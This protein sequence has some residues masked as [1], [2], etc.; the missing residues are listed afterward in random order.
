MSDFPLL[1][2]GEGHVVPRQ[3]GKSWPQTHP[4]LPTP[5]RQ[6][7]RFGPHFQRLEDAL[8]EGSDPLVLRDDPTGL[9]PERVLVF[10]VVGSVRDFNRA[11]E[12]I[13]G[14]EY[15]TESDTQFP[16]DN[17]FWVVDRRQG[18]EGQPRR[19]MPVGGCVYMA[20]PNLQALKELLSLWRIFR[21]DGEFGYGHAKWRNLFTQL[22]D[23]RIWGPQDRITP[24]VKD[25]FQYLLDNDTEASLMIAVEI[26]LWPR[27]SETARHQAF[28]AVSRIIGMADG[29]ILDHAEILQIGY[30]AV[31]AEVPRRVIERLAEEDDV[32]LAISD[33]IMYVRPQSAA[34]LLPSSDPSTSVPATVRREDLPSGRS[35]VAALLD[36]MPVQR[37]QGLDGQIIVDD[38]DGVE[39]ESPVAKRR[40]GTEMAS[41]IL[42]GDLAGSVPEPALSRPLHVHPVLWAPP[43]DA[44]EQER[45][46]PRRLLI[47]TFY[48]AVLRMKKGEGDGPPS[49]PDV[50]LINV[51]LGDRRRPYAN[52]ASPWARLL[53]YLACRFHL[54]FLVSAGNISEPLPIPGFQGLSAFE[55]A[56][57]EKRQLAILS[58]LGEQRARRTL[59]SPA[60]AI[61]VVTVGA[62]HDQAAESPDYTGALVDPIESRTLPNVSSALGLG[63]LRAIKPDI[64][65]PGGRE[66]VTP[67]LRTDGLAVRPARPGRAFGIQ[68]AA[69]DPTGRLDHYRPT[70]GTSAATALATHLAH[71][72]FDALTDP[73]NGN[74]LA[75]ANPRYY[76]VVV[77]ALLI[78]GCHWDEDVAEQVKQVVGPSGRYRSVERLDNVARVLGRGLPVADAVTACAAD[79]ATLIGYGE[80]KSGQELEYK[81]PLPI[82]L[83]GCRIPR[84]VTITLTWFS[85]VTERTRSYQRAKLAVK[86]HSSNDFGTTERSLQPNRHATRRGTTL[87]ERYEGRAVKHFTN[88]DRL[89]LRITCSTPD[90]SVDESICYGIVVTIEAG[91]QVPIYEEIRAALAVPVLA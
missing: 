45:F 79:R 46:H 75:D 2:L 25:D 54:L 61:N 69:P 40:H 6:R 34:S 5:A 10:E 39:D 64:L 87:H 33:D 17:D 22:K 77:R 50:F 9:A 42:H 53:D 80:I 68:A 90:G 32:Q 73:D 38:P 49:S 12:R 60:E 51:S 11:I 86:G 85:P 44:N 84:S 24:E 7:E 88:D 29:S 4:H 41:L 21:T 89:S 48:R 83:S 26:E 67:M 1:R 28:E 55:D 66:H 15:L 18:R 23:L 62:C 59:L 47:D 76:A 70:S 74:I 81:V 3:P 36:G 14:L 56:P 16:P 19:D 27:T 30:H 31:L 91:E 37:H 72:I 71:R 63:H 43:G 20:M 78:H 8:A 35:P 13:S 65:L 52:Q 57:I 58:A 82:S